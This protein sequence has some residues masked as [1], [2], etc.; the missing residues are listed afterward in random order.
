VGG[1]D[2]RRKALAEARGR[3]ERARRALA[4]ERDA[5]R[6]VGELGEERI[7]EAP[8]ELELAEDLA[9][10]VADRMELRLPPGRGSGDRELRQAEETVRHSGERGNDDDRLP[11]DRRADD[12]AEAPDR[13][14]PPT[15]CR[16]TSG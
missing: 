11:R 8:V 1:H 3:V 12:L 13:L 2:A 7:D 6:E 16:R 10:Q 9:V 15:E 4:D 5:A 14:G